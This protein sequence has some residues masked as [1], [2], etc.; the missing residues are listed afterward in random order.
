MFTTP[1]RKMRP[2][3]GFLTLAVASAGFLLTI[4]PSYSQQIE[5]IA[6]IVNDEVI[7]T[8]DV[9]Q[10]MNLV[11]SSSGMQPTQDIIQRIQG[12]VVRTLIDEKLQLQEAK[13]YEVEIADDE[14]SQ[15]IARL[16]QQNNL[17]AEDLEASLRSSGINSETLKTQIRAELAWNRVVNG[18]L[19]SRVSVTQDEIDQV[20]GQLIS[21]AN[22]P[23]YLVSEILLEIPTLQQEDEIRQGGI[24][25]IQQM[26][27]GAPFQ[28]VAQQFSAAASA[29]QGGD[30]G[31]VQDGQ[32]ETSLNDALRGMQPG[33]ISP[34]IRTPGGWVLL[35]LRDKR[36]VGGADPLKAKIDLRQILIPLATDADADDVEDAREKALSVQNELEGCDN[37]ERA[38]RKARNSTITDLGQ[39][40]ISDLAGRFRE[41]AAILQAGEAS[42]PIRT[43]TGLNILVA[44]DRE[45]VGAS[46][47]LPSREQIEDRL[48]NQ[49]LSMFARRHM[50]DLRRDATIELR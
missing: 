25:L 22:R 44:C 33:Q 30:I 1:L 17:R 50:R 45:D 34:P 24:Q 6:A 2:F 18:L 11:L 46:A 26:Q 42:D 10:R 31:W 48:Y 20:L 43:E 41:T 28:V 35:A 8:Y 21:S 36:I 49:Q 23:Q 13:K 19:G 16:A 38:A 32:L 29:A 5:R 3:Q 47:Q 15:A 27:Q 7:S 39:M 12:Q 14:V 37:L 40:S 4:S 9:Q